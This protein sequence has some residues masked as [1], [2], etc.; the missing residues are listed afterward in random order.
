[1]DDE[2]ETDSLLDGSL[3]QG[4][5]VLHS[6]VCMEDIES[7][8]LFSSSQEAVN[9]LNIYDKT[10][11]HVAMEKQHRTIA[12]ILICRGADINAPDVYGNTPLHCALIFGGDI[13]CV[14]LL[15]E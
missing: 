6:A 2:T 5:T 8:T 10:P 14:R 13:T 1:M 3:I 11:L 7:V 9:E 12:E 15:L 4:N